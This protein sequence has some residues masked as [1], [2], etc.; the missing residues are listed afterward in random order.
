MK[1]KNILFGLALLVVLVIAT[2]SVLAVG[3]LLKISDVK[4]NTIVVE[5]NGVS[6]AVKP[7]EQV[8]IQFTVTNNLDR[9]ITGISGELKFDD[10][11]GLT[12]Q[13]ETSPNLIAGKSGELT[14]TGNVPLDF[15]EKNYPVTLSVSGKDLNDKSVLNDLFTFDLQVKQDPADVII[16]KLTLTEGTIT[17]PATSTTLKVELTNQGGNDEDDVNVKV[18]SGGNNV[19]P[20]SDNNF[21]GKNSQKTLQFLIPAN[22]LLSG[23]NTL[24]V[25][26]SYRNNFMKDT[27]SIKVSAESCSLSFG[28]LSPATSTLVLGKG[29]SPE[30]S[31]VSLNNPGNLPI[32][33]KWYVDGLDKT[34]NPDSNSFAYQA[35]NVLG[36]HTVKVVVNAGTANEIS[37]LWTVT[38]SDLP[39]AFEVSSIF[40]DGVQREATVQ[41]SI[42]VKN[43]GFEPLT[44]IKA[45]LVGEIKGAAY[46]AQWLDSLP[47]EL[48]AGETKTVKLQIT[49][50]KN[51]E[52]GKHIIGTFRVSGNNGDVF[53]EMPIYIQPK[54]FL[55]IADFEVNGK[56]AGELSLVEVNKILVTVKNDY[57]ADLE[58]VA[59]TVKI[60]DVDEEDLDEESDS[61][62]LDKGDEE[63]LTFEFDLTSETVDQDQ[64]TVEITAEGTATDGSKHKVVTTK[65]VEVDRESHQVMIKK[66]ALSNGYVLCYERTA[67]RLD[68]EN[69]GENDED[70]VE[71]RVKNAA[72]GI[73]LKK[74]DIKIEKFSSDDNEYSTSFDL[75]IANAAAGMYPLTVE[76][77]LDG[78]LT[79]TT[80]T[81]LEVGKNCFA[82]GTTQQPADEK[83][84]AELQKQLEDYKQ[85]KSGLRNSGDYVV[86]LGALVALVFIAVTL[87]IAVVVVKKKRL[88]KK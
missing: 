72:L 21:V 38:V 53:K 25:E 43:I 85:S 24:N 2:G 31:V 77:Y 12:F 39:A 13:T 82:D 33:Y 51:E 9:T 18:T 86:L 63:D 79:A 8:T 41:T 58:D 23:V 68:L 64:Y 69:V 61:F 75:E 66:A 83:L 47:S 54:S 81:N 11:P 29:D 7:L 37:N 65:T 49:V 56:D 42:T 48:A 20:P 32:T 27:D 34:V 44:G 88:Q 17:C 19:V 71:I 30:F 22:K 59:V 28:S 1:A 60:L 76:V 84:V 80:E 15:V 3:D 62:D 40:F 74:S 55:T 78:E 5:E 46:N 73:D 67:L 52:A 10:L 35:G 50:P 16:S 87:S 70:N 57:T 14:I 6:T 45:E 26:V 4:V 36:D